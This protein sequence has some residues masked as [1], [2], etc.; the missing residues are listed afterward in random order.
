MNPAP[1]LHQIADWKRQFVDSLYRNLYVESCNRA[2][3]IQLRTESRAKLG[4]PPAG[5]HHPQKSQAEHYSDGA[6]APAGVEGAR[7]GLRQWRIEHA[8]GPERQRFDDAPERIDH[9]GNS[10][11]GRP[12]QRKPLFDGAYSR[13]LEVL[14]GACTGAEPSIIGQVEEPAGP[15]H[16]PGH[17][18]PVE[19]TADMAVEPALAFTARH[20]VAG[21][22]DFITDQ[23]QKIRCS[24]R[25]LIAPLV[26][27][28]ESAADLGE[29]LQTEPLEQLLKRQVFAEW[30]EMDLVVDRKDRAVVADHVDRIVGARH[31]R[32]GRGFGRTDGAGDQ[33]RL[34]G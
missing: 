19:I 5:A 31:G 20:R 26:S 29:L 13:L 30:H 9:R 28:D 32:M 16:A 22:N 17:G 11:I 21:K 27:G 18:R 33:H 24:W 6:I 4:R 23:R 14:V 8:L 10:A 1:N 34:R 7:G 15:F 2:A 3:R 25:R 12:H